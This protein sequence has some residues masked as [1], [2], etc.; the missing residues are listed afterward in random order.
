LADLYRELRD[1]KRVDD[2]KSRSNEEVASTNHGISEIGIERSPCFGTCPVYTLI[3]KSD[4]SFRYKG[5][6]FVDRIGEFTGKVDAWQY[7]NLAQF[8]KDAGY[9]ELQ[10]AY[11]RTVTDFETVY[12][13]VVMDGKRKVVS[14][15]AS[16]GPIKL[17]AIERLIDGLL[18]EAEW[19]NEPS[20]KDERK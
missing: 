4:G 11:D 20:R 5:L 9:M 13:T 10:D 19:D 8:I 1:D 17:W 6:H 12:T 16:A 15:Y 14:N 7:K 3:V 2:R 18:A